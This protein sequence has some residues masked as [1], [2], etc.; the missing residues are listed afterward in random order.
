MNFDKYFFHRYL[1]VILSLMTLSCAMQNKKSETVELQYGM[2][3][4]Q[5]FYSLAPINDVGIE[6]SNNVVANWNVWF[7]RNDK[8]INLVDRY[9]EKNKRYDFVLDISK[10]QRIEKAN[11]LVS[12][13]VLDILREE[14]E[15]S[16]KVRILFS[17]VGVNRDSKKMEEVLQ[18]DLK[19]LRESDLTDSEL[20]NWQAGES[21]RNYLEKGSAGHIKFAV[22]PIQEGCGAVTLSIWDESGLQPL[23]H[24]IYE[25][26]VGRDADCS[27]RGQLFS[28]LELG[29]SISS[30]QPI[31]ENNKS[32]AAF[33]IFDLPGSGDPGSIVWF[34]DRR[35]Y[36]IEQKNK[37]KGIYAWKT[38]SSLNLYART[39]TQLQDLLKRAQELAKQSDMEPY[40]KVAKEFRKKIFSGKDKKDKS[41][42]DISLAAFRKLVSDSEQSPVVH[43]R[44]STAEGEL[45]FLP[46]SL[47]TANEAK[48]FM[49]FQPLPRERL[50]RNKTCISPWT[51]VL[52]SELTGFKPGSEL[53]EETSTELQSFPGEFSEAAKQQYTFVR[54]IDEFKGYLQKPDKEEI[55]L[56]DTDKS[57]SQMSE[58]IV[59]LAHHAD[60][61]FWFKNIEER[62]SIE[63]FGGTF[64]DG[65]AAIIFSCSVG[66]S[67]P[68]AD[69][70]I[71]TLNDMNIDA[72]IVSPFEVPGDFGTK[73]AIEFVRAIRNAHRENQTPTVAKL[74]TDAL[75]ETVKHFEE[76]GRNFKDIGLE[77]VFLGDSSIRLCA[78]Q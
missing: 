35:E 61:N 29:V 44:L 51:F 21:T 74:Y 67:G 34:I 42:A 65:S 32:D 55:T 73:L 47:L 11:A 76:S 78:N 66:G 10:F 50:F 6:Y 14:E 52:P 39:S 38:Q 40:E 12:G 57:I 62:T 68:L 63:D 77:F 5:Q 13:R 9:L 28:G 71:K 31:D 36:E 33:H 18:V 37:R 22:T 45:G 53:S 17:G 2:A 4:S 60:G 75:S 16:F 15:P 3:G 48:S 56:P 69:K 25:Y 27:L 54:T 8:V 43:V 58:G 19:K 1:G 59:V 64:R 49:T 23:D 26:P 20:R 7:Q 72:M 70:I 24:I 41:T 30:L 46:F